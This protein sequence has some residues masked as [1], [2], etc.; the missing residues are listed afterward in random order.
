MRRRGSGAGFSLVEVVLAL[1]IAAFAIITI[2]GLFGGLLDSNR[3]NVERREALQSVNSL[4][5]FL[6]EQEEG[7]TFDEIYG[8]AQS[9]AEQELVYVTYRGDTVTRLPDANSR[10]IVA[11]WFDAGDMPTGISINDLTSAREGR[12]IKAKLTLL[13]DL[14]PDGDALPATAD[15]Y[16]HA[17][18]VF[19]AKISSVAGPEFAGG[20]SAGPGSADHRDPLTMKIP[21]FTTRHE[22]P[23]GVYAS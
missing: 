11:G 1:G 5:A 2:I 22:I 15:A 14:T 19:I 13:T 6:N 17:Y 20:R 9:G 7:K 10:E 8:W 12:W 23:S 18:L 16:P 4:R 3:Y 21:C